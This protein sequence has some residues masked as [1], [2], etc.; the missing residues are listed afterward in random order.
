MFILKFNINKQLNK[1][2]YLSFKVTRYFILEKNNSPAILYWLQNK[3]KSYYTLQSE[4]GLSL[5]NQN[6]NYCFTNR[7]KVLISIRNKYH[8]QQS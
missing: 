3:T 1:N 4:V 8:D 7:S 2:I 5:Y 6:Q